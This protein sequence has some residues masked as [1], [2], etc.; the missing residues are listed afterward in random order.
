M[1]EWL[2]APDFQSGIRRFEPDLA[3]QKQSMKVLCLVGNKVVTF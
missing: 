1:A 2:N 3:L